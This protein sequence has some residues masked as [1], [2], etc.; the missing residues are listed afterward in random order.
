MA[1]AFPT[2]PVAMLNPLRAHPRLVIGIAAGI[3]FAAMLPDDM[4]TARRVLLGWNAG[5]WLYLLTTWTMMAR[6]THERMRQRSPGT[7]SAKR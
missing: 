5:T 2:L 1:C 6:A 7:T 4:S 3:A